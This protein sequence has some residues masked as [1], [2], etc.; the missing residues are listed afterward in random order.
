MAEVASGTSQFRYIPCTCRRI[1]DDVQV[2]YVKCIYFLKTKLGFCQKL[3][4]ANVQPSWPNNSS[5][6]QFMQCKRVTC[7]AK[8]KVHKQCLSITLYVYHTVNNVCLLQCK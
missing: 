1:I 3:K 7:M 8:Q 5:T 4:K 6:G 2:Q